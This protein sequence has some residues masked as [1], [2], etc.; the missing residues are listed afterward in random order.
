MSLKSDLLEG[1]RIPCAFMGS[2]PSLMAAG[3][4][5]GG[6]ECFLPACRR[7][8]GVC[9]LPAFL[10]MP[11]LLFLACSTWRWGGPVLRSSVGGGCVSAC[12]WRPCLLSC[13]PGM[14]RGCGLLT[15]EGRRPGEALG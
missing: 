12:L 3:E 13:L 9:L 1:G 15:L 11:V 2:V 8:L 6:G 5:E 7:L 10:P 4:L 14:E